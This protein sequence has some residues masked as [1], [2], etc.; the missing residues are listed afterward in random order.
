MKTLNE[1][2]AGPNPSAKKIVKTLLEWWVDYRLLP[3]Q[4]PQPTIFVLFFLD[5]SSA[6]DDAEKGAASHEADSVLYIGGPPRIS[7]VT[8]IHFNQL[9]MI[10][11]LIA[12]E[13]VQ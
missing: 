3:V 10:R 8:G 13:I 1:K 5:I 4:P 9:W 12:I 6:L 11:L 2:Y 7:Q